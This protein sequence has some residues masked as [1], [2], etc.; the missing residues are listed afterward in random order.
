MARS[1]SFSLDGASISAEINKVDRKKIYGWVDK[2]AFDRNGEECYMG[3]LSEDG[4]TI[5]EKESFE[6]GYLDNAG[7]WLEK[8]DL[9]L[10]D[11]NDQ[12]LEKVESSFK[13]E[14]TI[15]DTVSIDEYLLYNA[16]SVYQLDG[17]DVETLLAKVKACD[18]IYTFE[19]NY[20]AS[21][22]P[23]TAF[24][25]DNDDTLFM[26]IGEKSMVEFISLEERED[27]ISDEDQE[28]EVE[29]DDMDFGMM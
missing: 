18:D 28:D 17:D 15:T 1:L 7:E 8:N 23:D 25:I 6:M 5:F 13:S 19:Y 11:E 9:L 20:I 4:T 21:Y 10:V 2:K 27:L 29:D 22:F 12:E 24:L 3:S 14:I 26:V 16:K